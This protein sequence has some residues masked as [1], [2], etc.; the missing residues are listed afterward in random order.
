MSRRWQLG[1]LE[2]VFGAAC[3]ATLLRSSSEIATA[4]SA[5]LSQLLEGTEGGTSIYFIGGVE[6]PVWTAI[7][8]LLFLGL[9][10]AGAERL[11]VSRRV[12]IWAPPVALLAI[13]A[14]GLLPVLRAGGAEPSEAAVLSLTLGVLAVVAFTSYWCAGLGVRWIRSTDSAGTAKPRAG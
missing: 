14:G 7:L 13:V 10:V 6:G 2:H 9:L 4:V 12:S 8:G 3:T 1:L 5:P 11:V